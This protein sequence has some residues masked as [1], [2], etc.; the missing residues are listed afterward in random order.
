MEPQRAQEGSELLARLSCVPFRKTAEYAD[1]ETVVYLTTPEMVKFLYVVLISTLRQAWQSITSAYLKMATHSS[2][3]AW[4]IPWTEEPG[5]LWSMGPQRVRHNLMTK[6]SPYL[7]EL[8]GGSDSKESACCAGDP[9]SIPGLGRSPGEGNGNPLQCS[10]LENPMNG[11]AWW[12]TVHG[13]TK[14]WTQLSDLYLH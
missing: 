14:S 7:H 2:I 6:P 5:K 4:K 11:G 8:P 12:A 1:W 3:L 13:V 10:C 9:G